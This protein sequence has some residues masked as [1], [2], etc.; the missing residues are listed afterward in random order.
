MMLFMKLKFI[1]LQR[2]VDHA[3]PEQTKQIDEI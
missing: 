2:C 3:G 1:A